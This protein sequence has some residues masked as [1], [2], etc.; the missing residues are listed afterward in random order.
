M[1]ILGLTG[2][3]GTGKSTVVRRLKELAIPVHEADEIVHGLLSEDQ[4]VIQDTARFFPQSLSNGRIDRAKLAALVFINRQN[5]KILEEIIHPRVQKA[6]NKF[7]GRHKAAGTHL[8]ALD[9]PLLYEKGYDGICDAVIVMTCLKET[10]RRRILMRPG[11]R[12][13]YLAV[14][15]SQQLP[16]EEKI[17]RADYV[18]DSEEPEDQVFKKL[19]LILKDVKV[20]Y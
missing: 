13:E 3:T 18:L 11:M 9:V 2:S 10:Q 20:K 12:E 6:R 1:I 15:A 16:D 19:D 5:L 4:R 17:K 7:L 14:L 8:V